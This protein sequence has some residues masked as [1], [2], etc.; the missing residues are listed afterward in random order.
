MEK[1]PFQKANNQSVSP[2]VPTIHKTWSFTTL[3]TWAWTTSPCPKPDVSSPHPH[4]QLLQDSFYYYFYLC[5]QSFIILVGLPI[6][7]LC[8]TCSVSSHPPSLN[9]PNNIL[10]RVQVK[11]TQWYAYAGTEGRWRYSS[12]PLAT[13]ELEVGGW[14]TSCPGHF[15]PGKEPVL[16]VQETGCTLGPVQPHLC[17]KSSPQH[18]VLRHLWS[19]SQRNIRMYT[20]W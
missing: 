16:T 19:S 11:V 6:K 3:L 10:W 17:S 7:I 18:H 13:S 8:T 1:S 12:N 5:F 20:K 2:S 9:H 4:I 14:W 15:N